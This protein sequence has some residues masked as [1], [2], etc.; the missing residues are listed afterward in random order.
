[1]TL[2]QSRRTTR[3]PSAKRD[4]TLLR[5]ALFV[6]FFCIAAFMLLQLASL[7]NALPS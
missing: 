4:T 2:T 5:A 6:A 7:E 3:R 1:M